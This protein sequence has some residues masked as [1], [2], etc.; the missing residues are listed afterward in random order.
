MVVSALVALVSLAVAI[1]V[2][3]VAVV[4]ADIDLDY[5]SVGFGNLLVAAEIVGLVVVHGIETF[6]VEME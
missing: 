2:V 1:V 5:V 3:V 6:A 4:A